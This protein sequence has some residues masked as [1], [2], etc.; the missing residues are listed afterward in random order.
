[1]CN[2]KKIKLFFKMA[3]KRKRLNNN[4]SGCVFENYGYCTAKFWICKDK[5]K[6]KNQKNSYSCQRAL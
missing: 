3:F 5:I 4:L 2:M 6:I 1:M